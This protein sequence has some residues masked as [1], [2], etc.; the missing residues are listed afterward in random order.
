MPNGA[1]RSDAF[2]RRLAL[3]LSRDES[4]PRPPVSLPGRLASFEPI[5]KPK[6]ERVA[7]ASGWVRIDCSSR[8][9]RDDPTPAD[10]AGPYDRQRL[11]RMDA[12]FTA[13]LKRALSRPVT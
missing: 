6:P 4:R 10:A 3:L 2:R 8:L 5:P 13:R 12:R 9:H 7:P 11:L 1:I